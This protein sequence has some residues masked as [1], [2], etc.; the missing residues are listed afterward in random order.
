MPQTDRRMPAMSPWLKW[1]VADKVRQPGVYVLAHLIKPPSGPADHTHQNV[2]YIGESSKPLHIRW[3]AFHR[4]A[5]QKDRRSHSGG[6]TYFGKFNDIDPALHVAW[7]LLEEQH[8]S[9]LAAQIKYWERRLLL[10]FAER[11]RA[12]G[13]TE[14]S[15]LPLCNKS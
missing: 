3:R 8:P 12:E 13:S 7:L 4:S 6:R 9:L 14:S 5:Q 2:V 10:E 1:P 15:L 11:R